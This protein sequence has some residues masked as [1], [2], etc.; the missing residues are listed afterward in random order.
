M[1]LGDKTIAYHMNDP[2][3]HL[4]YFKIEL[5]ERNKQWMNVLNCSHWMGSGARNQEAGTVLLIEKQ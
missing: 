1:Y 5:I 2:G 3:F 4:Y